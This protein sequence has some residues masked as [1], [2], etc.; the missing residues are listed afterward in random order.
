MLDIAVRDKSHVIGGSM[1][2]SHS[3]LCYTA[4]LFQTAHAHGSLGIANT[5][6]PLTLCE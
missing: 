1:S 2:D 3:R 4:I 5:F 6:P